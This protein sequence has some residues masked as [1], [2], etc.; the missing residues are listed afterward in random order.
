MSNSL[1]YLFGFSF[2]L[3]PDGAA[4]RYNKWIADNLANYCRVE[5]A[6]QGLA[7]QWEI[8]DALI[9]HHPALYRAL[10]AREL[11]VVTPPV[12]RKEQID[13][14]LI[15]A[16]LESSESRWHQNLKA[17]I[18]ESKGSSVV[19]KLNHILSDAH[20]YKDFEGLRLVN[21]TRPN[22][23]DLF[24]EYRSLPDPAHY[25]KGLGFYQRIRVNRLIIEAILEDEDALT[26]G[27][28][29]STA[30]VLEAALDN[31]EL[32]SGTEILVQAH[33]LHGPRCVTQITGML[34]KLNIDC[35]VIFTNNSS[36]EWDPSSAQ[37]WCQSLPN[38]Q[39]YERR[40]EHL[41]KTR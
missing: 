9:E 26:R 40:I 39:A 8:A 7:V 23:G 25:P 31:Y 37:V 14:K 3:Q 28:Y 12:F 1:R 6:P 18:D 10:S 13:A 17:H 20:F 4:G 29:L 11:L 5:S 15:Q 30:G 27:E 32:S 38:W 34:N 24:T 16:E 19:E 36:V 35:P 22:L 41:V 33:P 2:S 21:L